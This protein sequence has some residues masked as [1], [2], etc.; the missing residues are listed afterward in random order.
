MSHAEL[1][2]DHVPF[3]A[4][5]PLAWGNALALFDMSLGFAGKVL[6]ADDYTI[7]AFTPTTG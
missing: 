5:D 6:R 2:L 3:R 1:Q 4:A 7:Q